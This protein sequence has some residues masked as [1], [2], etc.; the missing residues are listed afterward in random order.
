M[1]YIAE[2]EQSDSKLL[3]VMCP[4][5]QVAGWSG[6]SLGTKVEMLPFIG[7]VQ[8]HLLAGCR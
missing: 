6:G 2:P 5:V 4:S 3:P 7:T 1:Q 8:G